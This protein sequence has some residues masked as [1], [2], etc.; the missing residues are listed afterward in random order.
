MMPHYTDTISALTY[1][2]IRERCAVTEQPFAPNSAVRFVIGQQ[3]QMPG[4]LRWPVQ[5]LTLLFD[6]WGFHR[7]PHERR[8]RK[9][10]AWENSRWAVCRNLIRL[11]ARLAAFAWYDLNDNAR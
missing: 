10:R 5:C 8:W 3:M 6:A 2:L 7:W 11:N 9:I 4:H 1:S